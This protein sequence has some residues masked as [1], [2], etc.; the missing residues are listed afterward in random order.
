[1]IDSATPAKGQRPDDVP[2][3][4]PAAD[5]A[6]VLRSRAY[7]KLLVL[8]A[9]I[10]VPV[11]ALAYGFLKVVGWLQTALFT[12]LPADLGFASPP[13]WWPVPIVALSGLLTALA[14]TRLPGTGGH[15]PADGFHAA[16]PVP[17]LE[18]TRVRLAALATLCF[19][20]VLGPEA[21]LILIGSGLG[22]LA[23]RLAS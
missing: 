1:M 17:P 10:G 9:L 21:P 20:A 14:I 4:A 8:A 19:G 3:A 11:S 13:V 2:T 18:P 5:P 7:A 15:S 16:R 12:D 6:A 23:V 22:V